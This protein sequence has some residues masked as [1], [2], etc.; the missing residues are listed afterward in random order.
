M[1]AG[2]CLS[3]VFSSCGKDDER[4]DPENGKFKGTTWVRKVSNNSSVSRY[5]YT[6]TISF[7]SGK[8]G[9]YNTNG[10]GQVYSYSS[11]S[12]SA[13]TTENTTNEFT[14][15]YSPE[16]GQGTYTYTKSGNIGLF[17]FIDDT[18]MSWGGATY[19]LQ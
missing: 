16:L 11:K 8:E 1:L 19:E 12:W 13:K 6:H 17:N 10:W 9:T 18:T 4:I 5:E 14:Y 7:T 15:L 2:L 3:V